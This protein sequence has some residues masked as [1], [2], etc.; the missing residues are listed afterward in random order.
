MISLFTIVAI[1]CVIAI[2]I[3][4]IVFICAFLEDRE[5]RGKW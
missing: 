1:S 4:T 2:S 5:Q 3:V